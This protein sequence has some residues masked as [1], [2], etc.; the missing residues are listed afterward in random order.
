MGIIGR[1]Q[2]WRFPFLAGL[3]GHAAMDADWAFGTRQAIGAHTGA[4][5]QYVDAI[6]ACVSA[7]RPARILHMHW[8]GKRGPWAGEKR[9]GAAYVM[10]D[11]AGRMASRH[12]KLD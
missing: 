8:Y 9:D 10:L 2:N 11:W 6:E 12:N 4:G 3:A 5:G 1:G 7:Y